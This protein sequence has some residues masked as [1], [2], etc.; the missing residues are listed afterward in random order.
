M[1]LRSAFLDVPVSGSRAFKIL[2][3][4]SFFVLVLLDRFVSS[5]TIIFIM[6]ISISISLLHLLYTIRVDNP[7][8]DQ[9]G[10]VC[11]GTPTGVWSTGQR[12]TTAVVLHLTHRETRLNVAIY[13]GRRLRL[14]DPCVHDDAVAIP[15]C[16]LCSMCVVGNEQKC[17]EVIQTNKYKRAKANKIIPEEKGKAPS[18]QK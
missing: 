15:L 18:C 7:Q 17:K 10:A 4:T 14:G 5:T 11:S 2:Y 12:P 3:I 13:S 1:P 16:M 9:S 8:V 6:M